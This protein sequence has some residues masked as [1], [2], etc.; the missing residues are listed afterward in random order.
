MKYKLKNRLFAALALS[1]ASFCWP[2]TTTFGQDDDYGFIQAVESAKDS[3]Q[4]ATVKQLLQPP[5]VAG[6]ASA[7]QAKRVALMPQAK[8]RPAINAGAAPVPFASSNVYGGAYIPQPANAGSASQAS[9]R[10]LPGADS[11]AKQVG[12]SAQLLMPQSQEGVRA[13]RDVPPIITTASETASKPLTV[14]SLPPIIGVS[15]Q[16]DLPPIVLMVQDPDEDSSELPPVVSST[17]VQN[18]VPPVVTGPLDKSKS[19]PPLLPPVRYADN[20]SDTSMVES[21]YLMN[22]AGSI[23]QQASNVQASGFGDG[24]LAM[25]DAPPAVNFGVA[26]PMQA[27]PGALPGQLDAPALD[28]PGLIGPIDPVMPEPVQLP[29]ESPADMNQMMAPTVGNGLPLQPTVT[30]SPVFNSVV[31]DA[32]TMSGGSVCGCQNC[33]T[34]GCYNPSEIA[35]TFNSCGCNSMARR[36]MIAEVLYFDREDGFINNSNFGTL[37]NFDPEAGWRFTIGRRTDS[38][39]GREIS[40]MGTLAIEQ[41]RNAVQPGGLIQSRFVPAD[42]FNGGNMRAFFNA[43]EQSQAKET[44]LHSLEFNRVK[45]GWDVMKSFVGLRY[46][47]VDDSYSM[48]S[49]SAAV[50]PSFANPAGIPAEQGFF[51]MDAV[52]HLIG[53]HI[54]GE[55]YYDVGYRWSLSGFSKA[56]IYA[57]FNQFDTRLVSNGVTFVDAEDNNATIS[58][59]YEAGLMAKYRLTQR[60][61]FRAGYNILWLGEMG[62]VSDNLANRT[63]QLGISLTPSIGAGTSDSDDMFFHGFSFGFELYR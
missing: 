25:Q 28:V 27:S 54:G 18:L 59:S 32:S 56:G 13:E 11:K 12:Y 4:T 19:T 35:G 52:N 17:G 8:S 31:G 62:T 50:A 21:T 42:G 58:T 39:R 48:F 16:D 51:Q 33:G 5:I 43:T 15:A 1:G 44:F 30:D 22:A 53:P 38:T 7:L 6:Q 57:N 10:E 40:Y 47:L 23:G 60:A 14:N 34:N 24:P 45:W 36:Y 41:T 20:D 3:P 61:Q 63:N 9:F 55:L 29:T 2:A 49:Q 46:F 37:N 26:E